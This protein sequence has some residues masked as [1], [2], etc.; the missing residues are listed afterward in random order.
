MLGLILGYLWHY[1]I[2]NSEQFLIFQK[3]ET[4]VT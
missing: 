3:H 1:A 4:I 2:S